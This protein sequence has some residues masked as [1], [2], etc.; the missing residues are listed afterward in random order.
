VDANAKLVGDVHAV[1]DEQS[2]VVADLLLE[3]LV[4]HPL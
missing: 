3:W 2:N 4:A 1:L